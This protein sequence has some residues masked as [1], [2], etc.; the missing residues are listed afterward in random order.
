MTK[1]KIFNFEVSNCAYG[2]GEDDSK[3]R[4]YRI[5]T[6]KL[7][8]YDEVE[9]TINDFL[10][11]KN[12]IDMKVTTVDADYHNNS[13]ANKIILVYTIIYTD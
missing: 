2:A 4:W 1:V 7:V 11:D 5:N 6:P 13:L 10:K 3:E 9:R 12:Y 8:S